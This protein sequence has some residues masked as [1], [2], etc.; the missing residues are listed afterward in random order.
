MTLDD[1]QFELPESHIA[2]RPADPQDSARLLVVHGNGDLEDR[3]V[4]DLPVYLE[5]GDRLVFNDTRVLPSA[6]EAVRPPR[7]LTGRAVQVTINL[8]AP[9]QQGHWEALARP[10]RRLEVGDQLDISPGFTAEIVDKVGKGRI[11]FRFCTPAG[12]SVVEML[13]AAGQMPLPPYI[14]RR[15]PADSLDRE[16][17]QTRY[18]SDDAQSI[19]A[20][21][22]GLH[23]T[24]RLLEAIDQAGVR[25][26]SVRLHVGA[27]TF[28]PLGET[29]LESGRLHAEWCRIDAETAA[30]LESARAEGRRIIPVGTT[31]LRTLETACRSDGEGSIAPF[32]GETDIFLKPGDRFMATDALM[33]N[34]HL[35]G[36]SLFMLVCALMGTDVMQAAYA[37][38]I[39]QDYRF[40]S[41]GDACLLLPDRRGR[42]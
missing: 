7:D 24:T 30:D 34:F 41:Y 5:P 40:Y 31:S 36:S 35:P 4:L 21:T 26:K 17:Y 11:L 28:A 16:T 23:F 8:L 3:T 20:P 15:R 12:R 27:G 13:D 32:E 29:E 33:T 2:L 14:A 25:R 22:A 9:R 38:A 1:F 42:P 6:L 18:A 39:K 37:H 19:A 10:G